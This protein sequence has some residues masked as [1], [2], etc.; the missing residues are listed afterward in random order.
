LLVSTPATA[1]GAAEAPDWA[2]VSTIFVHRCVMCHSD[3]GAARELRLDTYEGAIT[4]SE[5]GAVLV[6][7]DKAASELIRRILGESVPRMPFLAPSLPAD[8][9][10]V[11][12]RWVEA[13]LPETNNDLEQS[14]RANE[15]SQS[16]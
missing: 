9:I 12:L 13:G 3:L 14:Y 2:D 6:P 16:P 15:A 8:E 7:G 11:I 5:K 4:G 10:D 1:G